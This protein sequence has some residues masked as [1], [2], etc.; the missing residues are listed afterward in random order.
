[1]EKDRREIIR[2]DGGEGATLR[3]E[4]TG[5]GV[6]GLHQVACVGG[7]AGGV[8]SGRPRVV[9]ETAVRFVPEVVQ[10]S[11]LMHIAGLFIGILWAP[12]RRPRTAVWAWA[13]V[14]A[15]FYSPPSPHAFPLHTLPVPR[16]ARKTRDV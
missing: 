1:M 11:R 7:R 15:C 10:L 14:R 8:G 4:V 5:G 9:Y 12:R 3:V 2:F 13:W 6:D 16:A